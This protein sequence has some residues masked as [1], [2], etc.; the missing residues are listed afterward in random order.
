[1]GVLDVYKRQA[2]STLA[3][4]AKCLPAKL[5]TE[6]VVKWRDD[7]LNKLM[8]STVKDRLTFAAA[9]WRE[10]RVN[11]KIDRAITDPFEG[12]RVKVDINVGRSRKEFSLPELRKIFSAP[13]LQ[14]CPLYTSR[15]V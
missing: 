1:M 10:S 2:W 8:P 13:P 12:L 14:T 11:G 5:T 9:I 3:E 4:S 7:L 15:C 6:V